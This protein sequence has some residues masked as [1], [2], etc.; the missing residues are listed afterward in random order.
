MINSSN[1]CLFQADFTFKA[2]EGQ[3]VFKESPVTIIPTPGSSSFL[4]EQFISLVIASE[5]QVLSD[6]FNS[7]TWENNTVIVTLSTLPEDY[8]KGKSC[9]VYFQQLGKHDNNE[10]FGTLVNISSFIPGGYLYKDLKVFVDGL[11]NIRIITHD[12][13]NQFQ[14]ITGFGSAL[15]DEMTDPELKECATNVM[16]AVG[17]AIDHNKDL[18]KFFPPKNLPELYSINP[19]STA[20]IESPSATITESDS[21]NHITTAADQTA[22]AQIN[23]VTGIL[24]IDDEPLVQRFLCEMLKRLKYTA[25]GCGTAHHAINTLKNDPHA[26]SMAIVDMNLPDLSSE[27]L[28][29]QLIEIKPD[30]KVI[31]IS[32]DNIGETS[33][34]IL[35]KGASGYLQKPTTI[36]TLSETIN[37]VLTEST[38]RD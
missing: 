2:D 3:L 32:G 4:L 22:D 24:V 29:D 16:D 19:P 14:V 34:R 21:A 25:T 7:Q 36:K 26:Y 20:A 10:C 1:S 28:F 30:L 11:K 15:E 37:K 23:P 18:R 31:L 5:R 6:F 17:K 27:I 9:S 38:I 8:L 33:Q 35:D 12:L 13:N